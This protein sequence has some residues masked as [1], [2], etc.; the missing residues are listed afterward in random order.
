[1]S[2][3]FRLNRTFRLKAEATNERETARRDVGRTR[4]DAER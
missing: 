4:V 1:L 3:A 2:A